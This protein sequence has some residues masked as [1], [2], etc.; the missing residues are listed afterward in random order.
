MN[1]IEKTY[2]LNGSLTKRSKTDAIYLHHRAGSGDV[3]SIDRQHKSQNWT[4]IGYHFYVRKDGSI[5]RGRREDTVG[6]HAYGY[7]STSIGI[8][9]EGNFEVEEIMPEAQ[10]QAIIELV[11]YLKQKYGVSRVL[12]HKDVN[13]TACPGK[14]YPYEEIIN[15]KVQEIEPTISA[16]G[17]IADIQRTLNKKYGLNIA[18]DNIA[19]NETKKAIVIGLQKELNSQFKAG[20]VVDGVF[21]N[22]TK[23]KCET[24]R[25][26]AKG[27]ITW[28]LQARLVCLGYNTNGVDGVFGN[29]TYS[30]VI[31]FQKAKGIAVDGI[32]GKVTWTNLLA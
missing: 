2:S 32:V 24:L 16:Q 23:S 5:Y 31:S 17:A 18:V 7:N 19:G 27:N 15:G 4:C 8:C 3:E 20:L 13:A 14:N 21:G 1:I 10:K 11:N 25:K 6:A 22:Q 28:L 12:R 29:G 9:A 30:A 26:G